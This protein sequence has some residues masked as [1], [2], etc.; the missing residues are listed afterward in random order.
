MIYKFLVRV[1][2]VFRVFSGFRLSSAP[3]FECKTSSYRLYSVFIGF[4]VRVE[5]LSLDGH[6]ISNVQGDQTARSVLRLE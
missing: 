6:P 4:T 2:P 5:I 1:F 3:H